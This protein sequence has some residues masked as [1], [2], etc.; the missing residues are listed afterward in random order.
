MPNCPVCCS[1]LDLLLFGR[2][3]RQGTQCC[4]IPFGIEG[5]V[6]FQQRI[7]L[8]REHMGHQLQDIFTLVAHQGQFVERGLGGGRVVAFNLVFD[9]FD[10]RGLGE[11]YFV[12]IDI[13]RLAHGRLLK[14]REPVYRHSAR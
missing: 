9:R 13:G 5:A 8:Y 3:L 12:V 11:F 10:Q 7:D 6:L 14:E 1:V 4:F 2:Q